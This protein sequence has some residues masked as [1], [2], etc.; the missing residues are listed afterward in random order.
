M[1]LLIGNRSRQI[2]SLFNTRCPPILSTLSRYRR[3]CGNQSLLFDANG[4][5]SHQSSVR[6]PLVGGGRQEIIGMSIINSKIIHRGQRDQINDPTTCGY[7]TAPVKAQNQQDARSYVDLA[8]SFDRVIHASWDGHAA[9]RVCTADV[10]SSGEA[11]VISWGEDHDDS[12][13]YRYPLVWLRDNCRCPSCFNLDAKSKMTRIL[14]L[15]L[16]VLVKAVTSAEDGAKVRY[17]ELTDNRSGMTFDFVFEVD[18]KP[19]SLEDNT[20]W[21]SD[22]CSGDNCSGSKP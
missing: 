21:M 14:D 18:L 1:S 13:V 17:I 2:R 12:S 5:R 7:C 10:S 22:I 4:A 8:F 20:K 16:D 19:F 6:K 15:D 9:A 11:L 3:Y